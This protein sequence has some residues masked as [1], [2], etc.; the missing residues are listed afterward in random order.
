MEAITEELGERTN[1]EDEGEG[2]GQGGLPI[3]LG[4]YWQC[5]EQLRTET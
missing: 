1:C 5:L 2:D 4:N 3:E